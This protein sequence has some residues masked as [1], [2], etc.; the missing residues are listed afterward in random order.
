MTWVLGITKK[1]ISMTLGKEM[2][3]WY[4]FS[5]L[6]ASWSIKDLITESAF[7]GEESYS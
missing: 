1:H 3:C 2:D 7:A 4:F 5:R 6:C